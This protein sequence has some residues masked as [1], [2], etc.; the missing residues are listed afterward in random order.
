MYLYRAPGAPGARGWTLNSLSLPSSKASSAPRRIPPRTTLPTRCVSL[1]HEAA[2]HPPHSQ[3]KE[4]LMSAVLDQVLAANARYAAAFGD[5][6][7]LAL[8]PARRFAV[9]TCMDARIDPAKALGLQEGDAHVIRNA[10]G[11]ASDAPLPPLVLPHTRPL[12]D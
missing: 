11:P 10:G 2:V 8:P 6:G 9:L 7:S 12:H 3:Q 4:L 1:S 5:K